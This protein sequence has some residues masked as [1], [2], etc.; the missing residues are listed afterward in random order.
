ML[1]PSVAVCLCVSL[2]SVLSS[3]TKAFSI[4]AE[5]ALVFEKYSVS[6]QLPGESLGFFLQYLLHHNLFAV[7]QLLAESDQSIAP[8]CHSSPFSI[9][10]YLG[11]QDPTQTNWFAITTQQYLVC[12]G[13]ANLG[14]GIVQQVEWWPYDRKV[15]GSLHAAPW[16]SNGCPLLH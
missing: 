5:T 6:S 13:R 2:S 3:L 4:W 11:R 7:L 14:A 10:T 9:S 1:P 16:A 8:T 12:W 15:G